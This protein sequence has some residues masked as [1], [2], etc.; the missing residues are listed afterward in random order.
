MIDSSIHRTIEAVWRMESAKIIAKLTRMLRQVGL[1]EELAQDA[2]VSALEQW[3]K[4]GMPDNPGAW[5]MT[6]AK[7]RALDELRRRKVLE[8]THEAIAHEA[9]LIGRVGEN[10]EEAAEND[11]GNDLLRLMFIAC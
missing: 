8:R 5:L 7:N 11:I 6:S 10:P 2:L 1:A 4:M 9:P 3:P